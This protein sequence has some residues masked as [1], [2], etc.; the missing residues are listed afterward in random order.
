VSPWLLHRDDRWFRDPAEFRPGRWPEGP[1]PRHAYVPFGAGPRVCIGEPFAWMEAALLLATI[2][3][4]WS[5][6][7]SA[8]HRVELQP[9]VTLRP[10]NGMPMIVRARDRRAA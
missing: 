10:R 1:D 8:P 5:L 2:G 6:D 9:V 4:R 3:Q 7:L